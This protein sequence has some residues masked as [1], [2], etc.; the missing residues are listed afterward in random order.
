MSQQVDNLWEEAHSSLR[1][2]SATNDDNIFNNLRFESFFQDLLSSLK[3]INN[4]NQYYIYNFY[5][6]TKMYILNLYNLLYEQCRDERG[7]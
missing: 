2:A 5:Y 6:Y 3:C 1:L 7:N 4:K